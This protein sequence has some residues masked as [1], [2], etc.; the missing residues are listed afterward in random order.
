MDRVAARFRVMANLISYQVDVPQDG[1][2]TNDPA[3]GGAEL[4]ISV[5]PNVG[6]SKIVIRIFDSRN[7]SFELGNLGL[8]EDIQERLQQMLLRPSGLILLT[9]PTG[10][11]KTTAMYSALLYISQRAG[12]SMSISTIE[13]PV[14]CRLP[15][16]SQSQI[17][18]AK[19]F[20]YAV[21]LRSLL[22][23]DPQVIMVGEIRD[24]ET[25][26]IALQAGLTGHLVISTIHSGSSAGVFAR[27]TNMDL[28]PFLLASSIIGIMSV[29]L[30]RRNCEYCAQ[31]Y[32]PEAS[33]LRL[34]PAEMVESATFY[35]GVGCAECH[36]TGFAS[37]VALAELLAVDDVLRE[38]VL[39]RM[40][41]RSL[42]QVA[43]EQGMRTLWQRG[44]QRAAAGFTTLE[45]IFR[46]VAAESM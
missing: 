10:S 37:R 9:G 38:A 39:Q 8:D 25:A 33:L 35:R 22:R 14:E 26:S 4:R 1:H 34:L 23:Q 3:F 19:D 17:N 18:N 31:P 43:V 40:T 5:F 42:Q 27:L 13:D 2:V 44:I 24:A 28:E 7:R 29:R 20:S 11:G 32:Q 45:E 36:H 21:A 6:G 16:I 15:M 41:T 46:V 12:P 30:I